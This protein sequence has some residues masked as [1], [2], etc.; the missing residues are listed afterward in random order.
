MVVGSFCL[1]E[2]MSAFHGHF[3]KTKLLTVPLGFPSIYFHVVCSPIHGNTVNKIRS[4]PISVLSSCEKRTVYKG[5]ELCTQ[6]QTVD[7]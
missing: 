2:L 4:A 5:L 7:T 3:V 1:T 6:I